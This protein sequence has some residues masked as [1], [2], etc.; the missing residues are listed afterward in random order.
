MINPLS[1]CPACLGIRLDNRPAPYLICFSRPYQSD[2][3]GL[4]RSRSDERRRGGRQ[5][6]TLF[7]LYGHSDANGVPLGAEKKEKKSKGLFLDTGLLCAISGLSLSDFS[8]PRQILQVNAGTLAEQFAGQHLLYMTDF[9]R[10]PELYYWSRAKSQSSAEIDYLPTHGSS[11]IPVEVKAGKTSSLRSLQVF[12]QKKKNP[13]AVRF[14]LERPLLSVV[15]TS[16]PGP[17]HR[18]RLVSL[19]LYMVEQWKRFVNRS[20]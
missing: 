10:L 15:A 5:A 4:S 8:D 1:C 17:K 7:T 11:V 14:N 18:F 6:P 13:L 16:V 20:S 2:K 3:H 9:F 12:M 19:P